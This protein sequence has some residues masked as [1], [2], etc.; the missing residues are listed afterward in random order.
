[1]AEK[2][3]ALCYERAWYAKLGGLVLI[4][5][6]L[7]YFR[8]QLAFIFPSSVNIKLFCCFPF[9]CYLLIIAVINA[10][11]VFTIVISIVNKVYISVL[12]TI[13]CSLL[14]NNHVMFLFIFVQ[15]PELNFEDILLS[16]IKYFT[17]ET[18]KETVKWP[19]SILY[20]V[21]LTCYRLMFMS[22]V[23]LSTCGLIFG[24]FYHNVIIV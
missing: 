6:I 1:M 17:Y 15:R 14:R 13:I 12:A 7:L 20:I 3:C 16:F 23:I 19:F 18:E 8:N 9:Y 11:I 5:L 4:W 24:F 21:N 22:D 2:M 10:L